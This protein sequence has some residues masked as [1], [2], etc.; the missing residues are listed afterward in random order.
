MK[1]VKEHLDVVICGVIAV[2]AL[3]GYLVWPLP[4]WGSD[5]Q[6]RMTERIQQKSVAAQL[7]SNVEI[8]PG[9]PK[10]EHATIEPNVIEAKERANRSMHQQADKVASLAAEQNQQHRVE[11]I[12]GT[13][14]VQGKPGTPDKYI[15]LL[16]NGVKEDN[17]L[18]GP[19]RADPFGFKTDY[20]RQF[21]RWLE[22]LVGAPDMVGTPPKEPEVAALIEARRAEI[23]ANERA[24]GRLVGGGQGS[25]SGLSTKDTT[26]IKKAAVF[27]R[28]AKLHMYVDDNALQKRPWFGKSVPPTETEIFEA[29]VDTWFQQDVVNAIASLNDKVLATQPAE[30]RNV[31]HAPIKR[32]EA[33]LVGSASLSGQ[34]GSGGGA[35]FMAGPGQA[36]GQGGSPMAPASPAGLDF[37]RSMTGHVGTSEY[38]VVP[39]KIVVYIDPTY[40][41]EFIDELYRQ[42][43]GYTVINR[44]MRT[45]DPLEASSNGYLY[46]QVQVIR[47]ELAVDGRWFR[48]WTVPL[49]RV[50]LR[51]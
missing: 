51:A 44:C 5:L 46:G 26:L 9:G 49:M 22:K 34:P 38:D 19:M 8:I 30:A 21:P 43:N 15:P 10:L 31:G 41:N 47:L 35:L 50:G 17:Y 32:L 23:S 13:P 1:Y 39:M 2:I 42:N 11:V 45:V 24:T 25:S 4:G 27:S 18:P 33:I 29:L 37:N 7:V 36:S 12:K 3:V 14:A 28:A 16:A 20:E 48:S 40:E 6:A